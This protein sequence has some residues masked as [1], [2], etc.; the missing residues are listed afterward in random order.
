[1][2]N[3]SRASTDCR[4]AEGLK[5][6]WG[7]IFLR[8]MFVR[9]RLRLHVKRYISKRRRQY[10]YRRIWIIDIV[11]QIYIYIHIYGKRERKRNTFFPHTHTYVFDRCC[12]MIPPHTCN[13]K[14]VK[15]LIEFV[16]REMQTYVRKFCWKHVPRFAICIWCAR[17]IT[18]ICTLL[19]N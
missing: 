5:R 4:L 16:I 15:N 3:H 6:K 18:N 12:R 13:H 9:R 1:M 17:G 11:R 14:A 7:K 8:I 19:Y 2:I 10:C